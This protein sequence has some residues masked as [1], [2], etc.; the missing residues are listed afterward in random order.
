MKSN[1]AFTLI[2]L[3]VVI[4]IIAVISSV[5]LLSLGILGDDRDLQREARRLSSLIELA[6]DDAMIQG[7]EFGLEIMRTGYR[8]V[9]LDPLLDQW[10][11]LLGDDFLRPRQLT[12]GLEFELLLEDRR[13]LLKQDAAI[14]E[15][16]DDDRDL[17]DD[18]LPHI[19]IM[20]SGDV[21]PFELR[22]SRD[23]DQVT[24]TMSAAGELE[25]ESDDEQAL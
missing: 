24:V 1:R 10:H 21:S 14:T 6:S 18:Y 19:L 3:L 22:L 12:D 17:T 2:E 8:F 9:E 7:R 23:R 13:V 4:V 11:E 20:S 15:R 25:I 5:A 16:E